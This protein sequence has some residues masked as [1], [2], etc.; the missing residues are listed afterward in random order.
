[1]CV[2]CAWDVDCSRGSRASEHG[3]YGVLRARENG[4]A[5]LCEHGMLSQDGVLGGIAG[6]ADRCTPLGIAEPLGKERLYSVRL[7]RV[8]S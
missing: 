6:S 5:E 3:V 7:G 1:M 4:I 8:S 2:A